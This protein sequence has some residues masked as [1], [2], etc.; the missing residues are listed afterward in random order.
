MLLLLSFYPIKESVSASPSS[1]TKSFSRA[2]RRIRASDGNI[3]T[4]VENK[5][6]GRI[7]FFAKGFIA[8]LAQGFFNSINPETSANFQLSSLQEVLQ[9]FVDS[10]HGVF[11][12]SNSVCIG[13][14]NSE[15]YQGEEAFLHF[16]KS[17]SGS[18][19]Y[20]LKNIYSKKTEGRSNK[21]LP[22]ISLSDMN[23]LLKNQLLRPVI[24]NYFNS[25]ITDFKN[26]KQT[27]V[28]HDIDKSSR[29][30]NDFLYFTSFFKDVFFDKNN[31]FTGVVREWG[32]DLGIIS[33][34]NLFY[35]ISVS[36]MNSGPGQFK[37]H[38]LLRTVQDE[39]GQIIVSGL[40]S[41]LVQ[42]LSESSPP[43]LDQLTHSSNS[44]LGLYIFEFLSENLSYEE[45]QPSL[46]YFLKQEKEKLSFLKKIVNHKKKA[47]FKKR[48]DKESSIQKF[49]EDDLSPVEKIFYALEVLGESNDDYKG[50]VISWFRE[51]PPLYLSQH[52]ITFLLE[53][54]KKSTSLSYSYI[55]DFLELVK[56]SDRNDKA[57]LV[58][59]IHDLLKGEVF[60]P[61]EALELIDERI[62]NDLITASNEIYYKFWSAA[63]SRKLV[64]ADI[65][66][67]EPYGGATSELEKLNLWFDDFNKYID[68]IYRTISTPVSDDVHGNKLKERLLQNFAATVH[69]IPQVFSIFYNRDQLKDIKDEKTREE[70]F[71]KLLNHFNC[72]YRGF[73]NQALRRHD[74]RNL[75]KEPFALS[76]WSLGQCV[77]ICR[78]SSWPY[79]LSFV[80][81]QTKL[82]QKFIYDHTPSQL[83]EDFLSLQIESYE[84]TPKD[85]KKGKELSYLKDFVLRYLFGL[86]RRRIPQELSQSIESVL[87]KRPDLKD[88]ILSGYY[89]DIFFDANEDG[90]KNKVVIKDL[91]SI[92]L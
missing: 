2:I 64:M 55:F 48:E 86:H 66:G 32:D 39:N 18:L 11:R 5:E 78:Y 83:L 69:R 36:I 45:L 63:F 27:R 6:S 20:H 30:E 74:Q 10:V 37:E 59:E 51:N 71:K 73:K 40:L 61:E 60:Y 13:Y 76:A 80:N 31:M 29:T 46:S 53:K 77:H 42:V 85:D 21:E 12:E 89:F 24:G 4:V 84:A 26:A 35:M 81:E 52:D 79:N 22:N 44:D 58:D 25:K 88:K 43:E 82:I 1:L 17:I 9:S 92:T 57:K 70:V 33:R 28:L 72:Q 7:E 49:R 15:C 68:I 67:D 56:T 50:E 34:D 38:S 54:I 91:S 62:S 14:G 75:E 8:S 16:M 19:K 23:V 47:S 41:T 90:S 65:K 3:N 87:N